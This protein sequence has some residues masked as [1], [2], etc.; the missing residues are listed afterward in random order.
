MKHIIDT[1]ELEK[2]IKAM[3]CDYSVQCFD[4]ANEVTAYNE[5]VE[6]ALIILRA[7]IANSPQT[8]GMVLALNNTKLQKRVAVLEDL[9]SSAYNIANRNGEHTHWERFAGQ[10]HINGISP[11]TAKT[12]KI[13]P[14]D[15]ELSAYKPQADDVPPDVYDI[16]VDTGDGIYHTAEVVHFQQS[17]S[18]R[19]IQVRL[20][21]P[22]PDDVRK[23]AW[24]S[25]EDMLPPLNGD[26]VLAYRDDDDWIVIC[27]FM[28]IGFAYF[29]EQEEQYV[30]AHAITHWQPLPA[31]PLDKA[32]E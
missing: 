22:Q 13:L 5:G 21:E 15:T 29:S 6:N 19:M 26:E 4:S 31:P 23:D 14:S 9:L 17:G 7:L 3:K 25:V 30:T 18:K 20:G 12:F 2:R 27:L 10:L 16:V 11:I 24:I 8:D 28:D 32:R 1:D